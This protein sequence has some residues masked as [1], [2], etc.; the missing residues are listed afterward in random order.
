ME[1]WLQNIS[2]HVVMTFDRQIFRNAWHYPNKSFP[3]TKVTT[4]YTWKELWLANWLF[5]DIWSCGD[6]DIWTS[7]FSEMLEFLPNTLKCVCVCVFV[8]VCARTHACNEVFHWFTSE[9]KMQH[10]KFCQKPFHPWQVCMS[11]YDRN[12]YSSLLSWHSHIVFSF[13]SFRSI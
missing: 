11:L 3:L 2:G 1:L 12:I 6:L 4:W 5:T 13:I 8:S 7:K 10:I 9:A